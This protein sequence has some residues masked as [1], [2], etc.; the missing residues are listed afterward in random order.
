VTAAG[1]M[2]GIELALPVDFAGIQIQ[3]IEPIVQRDFIGEF[4]VTRV[5]P[6]LQL[7]S[8]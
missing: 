8:F 4:E 6:I 7:L 1:R 2:A 3:R 5:E